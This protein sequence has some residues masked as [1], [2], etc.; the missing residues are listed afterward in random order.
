MLVTPPPAKPSIDDDLDDTTTAA[1]NGTAHKEAK[2]SK[3]SKAA[4]PTAKPAKKA[5]AKT[6][7]A[8]KPAKKAPAKAEKKPAVVDIKALEAELIKKYK[9]QKI[10]PGSLRDAGKVASFGNKRTIE[11]ICQGDCGGTK[12]RIATSDLHQ[13]THCEPCMKANRANKRKKSGKAKAPKAPK[14]TKAK[15]PRTRAKK[16][17]ATATA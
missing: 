1:P 11:I 4:K 9:N 2:E 17:L 16:E 3:E 5:P 7:P 12:R 10:V 6:K 15:T 13:T 14:T 8:G